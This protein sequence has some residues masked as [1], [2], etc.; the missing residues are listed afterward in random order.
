MELL[1]SA[2]PYLLP[3]NNLVSLT[4]TTG[5]LVSSDTANK[6]RRRFRA[7]ADKMSRDLPSSFPVS[8]LLCPASMSPAAAAGFH[9]TLILCKG[10]THPCSFQRTQ[11]TRALE[12]GWENT[13]TFIVTGI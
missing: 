11:V 8:D 2:T 9:P 3:E 6:S 5:Y 4:E 7:C 13:A 10:I 1:G 12:Y